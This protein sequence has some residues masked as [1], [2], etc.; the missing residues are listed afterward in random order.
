MQEYCQYGGVIEA[1]PTNSLSGIIGSPNV[2]FLIEPDGGIDFI[3]S[4]DKV[5]Q[6]HFRNVSAITPQISIPNLVLISLNLEY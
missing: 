4:Y 6:N 1:C 5:N 3:C 2:S